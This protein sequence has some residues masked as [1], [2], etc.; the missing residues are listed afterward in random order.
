[1]ANGAMGSSR[2]S[3]SAIAQPA[4]ADAALKNPQRRPADRTQDDRRKAAAVLEFFGIQPGMVVLDLYSGGGYYSELL[5]YLVGPEGR[6]VAHNNT[7]YLSFAGTEVAERY[8]GGR[9][10]NVEQ[11]IAGNNELDLPVQRFDA[12]V[13][14]KAYHDVY[15]VDEEIG[16]AR[17]DRPE[18]LR[19]VFE[20]MKPGAVL[21]IVDHAAAPGAAAETGGTLHRID[22]EIIKSD[23]KAAGFVLEAQSDILRNPQDDYSTRVFDDSVRDRTD[24]VVMRFRK[25]L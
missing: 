20:A 3:S 10:P 23:M 1:M 18:F 2:P 6:V 19:E 4:A 8:R 12:V 5:S 7:P 13:M 24:R 16:W 21:G 17:I 22:P 9:L 25:P 11:L 15:F 14:I